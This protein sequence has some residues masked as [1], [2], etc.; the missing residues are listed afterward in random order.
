MYNTLSKLVIIRA[1]VYCNSTMS[2]SVSSLKGH[3]R[4]SSLESSFFLQQIT[5]TNAALESYY[6]PAQGNS[7]DLSPSWDDEDE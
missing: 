6:G 7:M 4:N 5:V 3:E 1:V 2:F